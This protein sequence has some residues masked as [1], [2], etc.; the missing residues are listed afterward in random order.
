MSI[1]A[2]RKV[3]AKPYLERADHINEVRLWHHELL[4]F[5]CKITDLQHG[6]DGILD[7]LC[8]RAARIYDKTIQR[9]IQNVTQRFFVQFD[10]EDE[11]GHIPPQP[12][13]PSEELPILYPLK[14]AITPWI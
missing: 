1:V 9:V 13:C 14:N 10:D 2:L 12:V 5:T 4:I 6:G 3:G 11:I 8:K 7:P